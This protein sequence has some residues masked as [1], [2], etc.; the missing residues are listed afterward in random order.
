MQ[1]QNNFGRSLLS[2][3]YIDPN[4][5]FLNHASFGGAPRIV[6]ES[7]K[8]WNE[9]AERQPLQFFLD[10]YFGLLRERAN[11]LA[12]FL[13]TKAENIVFIE[14]ATTGANT[15][16]NNFIP[17]LK[18]GDE[19]LFTDEVYPAVRN[20]VIH[21]NKITKTVHREVKIPLPISD[22]QEIIDIIGKS[23]TAQTKLFILDHISSSTGIIFPAKE[24]CEL[25]RNREIYSFVDGAHAPG[26]IDLNIEDINPDWYT[27]NCHKWLFTPKG[28][29]FLWTK[30]QNQEITHPLVISLF[31]GQGYL[32]E[33]DWTGTKNPAPWLSLDIALDFNNSFGKDN[34]INYIHNLICEARNMICSELN[35]EIIAPDDMIGSLA[36]IPLPIKNPNPHEYTFELRHILLREHNVEVPFTSL[37]DVIFVRPSAQI[38][39]EINDYKKLIKAL[40]KL[41]K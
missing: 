30:E 5:T 19:I 35:L 39:N 28:C 34:I 25:C 20:A 11:L 8:R 16:L 12:D 21:L 14:N 26:T 13:H 3:W 7:L 27:G 33:F 4:I 29:A 41:L 17:L 36:A 38:Y 18:P 32:R 9:I 22:N 24:I 37:G 23:F 40:H 6:I 1:E 10:E 2:N 15:V 31:Y